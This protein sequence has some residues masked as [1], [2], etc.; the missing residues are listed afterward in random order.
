[1]SIGAVPVRRVS[2]E[3]SRSLNGE[4]EIVSSGQA[5]I[6][7]RDVVPLELHRFSANLPVSGLDSGEYKVGIAVLDPMTNQPAVRFANVYTRQGLIF[8][9]GEINITDR[10]NPLSDFVLLD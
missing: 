7:L 1:M 10:N 5:S 4:G 9:L 2:E 6:D 8:E 3:Q